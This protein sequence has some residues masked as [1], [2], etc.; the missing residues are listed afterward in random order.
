[1]GVVELAAQL[2]GIDWERHWLRRENGVNG[3]PACV[4]FGGKSVERI[5]D[6]GCDR[7][8]PTPGLTFHFAVA[9]IVEED[10]QAVI[11]HYAYSS[12][13]VARGRA[14]TNRGSA[15]PPC[16]RTANTTLGPWHAR[17]R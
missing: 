17:P 1:M 12:T 16:N 6:H 14:R 10:L 5:A 2:C 9:L 15:S 4:H 8:S 7:R 3:S 11:E 13:C